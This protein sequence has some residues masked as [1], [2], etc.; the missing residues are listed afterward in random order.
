MG[1]SERLEAQDGGERGSSK[2]KKVSDINEDTRL[3]VFVTR[4]Y[5]D[6]RSSYLV[7]E[8]CRLKPALFRYKT[9]VRLEGQDGRKRGVSKNKKV[10]DVDE[11]IVPPSSTPDAL[12][13]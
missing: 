8:M 4:C 3:T 7:A 10:S 1:A 2:N 11:D 9:Q 13:S 6:S 5:D 12:L